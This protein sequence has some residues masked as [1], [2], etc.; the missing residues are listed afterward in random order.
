MARPQTVVTTA[1]LVGVLSALIALGVPAVARSNDF[2]IGY[3]QLKKDLRYSKK[4]TYA[5]HLTQ[6]LGRPYNGAKVALNEVKFHA[7]AINSKFKLKRVK[8]KN[9]NHLIA[10]A[11][12]LHADG[13]NFFIIDAPANVVADVALATK[14]RDLLLFNISARDDQL[15][16]ESCQRHLLHII[17]SNYMLMDALAQ[18]LV[19]RN[20]KQ[21]LMLTGPQLADEQLAQAF[22]RG[23]KRYGAEI[24]EERPFVLSNDPRERDQNN[25]ALLTADADYDVV[26]IADSDG[27]FSRNAAYQTVKPRPVVGSDGL[28]PAAWHWAWERHG[29]PQLE[30]RFEDVAERPMRGVDWAAWLAV[31]AIAEAVQRTAS[32]DFATLSAHLRDP[33]LIL[34]GFKG[35]RSNFRPWNGQLRQ[36]ILLVTHTWVVARAPIEGFLHQTN[37]MDTLGVDERESSCQY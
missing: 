14:D 26:F 11:E 17:P 28:A 16:R 20:W 23:A 31:K 37:N 32:A 3:L 33:E 34:D 9:T 5:R 15:R 2:T 4:R 13:V 29:A 27:E 7:A 18:Y 12:K 35:N 22:R 19:F 24:I 30:N 6:A 21:V 25:V 10:R 1:V 36:P 8:G